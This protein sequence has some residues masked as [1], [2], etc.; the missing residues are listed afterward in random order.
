MLHSINERDEGMVHE[1][2]EELEEEEEEKKEEGKR[3]E[4][5]IIGHADKREIVRVF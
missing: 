1:I 5:P 3:D 2:E 4:S